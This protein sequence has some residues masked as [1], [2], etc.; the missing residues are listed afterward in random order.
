MAASIPNPCTRCGKERIISKS[1]VENVGIS[2]LTHIETICPDKACQKI[3]DE[4]LLAQ[5][6]KRVA[7]ELQRATQKAERLKNLLVD[8]A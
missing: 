5:T 8:K 1:W 3:T 2:K 7:L 6:E 4:F